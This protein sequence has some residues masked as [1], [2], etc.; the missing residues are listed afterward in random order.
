MGQSET[1]C[2]FDSCLCN[3]KS[4]PYPQRPELREQHGDPPAEAAAGAVL[5][6]VQVLERRDLRRDGVHVFEGY[7]DTQ[8]Q[9]GHAGRDGGR[10]G[11][12]RIST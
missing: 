9:P 3:F 10:V 2:W 1:V 8:H 7:G 6:D 11:G 12:Q 5:L 4:S